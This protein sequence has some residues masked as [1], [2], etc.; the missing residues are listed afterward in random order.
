MLKSLKPKV[1]N[2]RKFAE[3]LEGHLNGRERVAVED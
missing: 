2:L 1:A 3:V